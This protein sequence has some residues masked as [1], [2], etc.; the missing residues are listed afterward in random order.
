[1]HTGIME[2]L[3]QKI[4]KFSPTLNRQSIYTQRSRLSRI[5]IN[6][7]IHVVRFAWKR[8]IGKKAKIMRRVAFPQELDVLDLCTDDLRE[9]L[10]PVNKRLKEIENLMLLNKTREQRCTGTCY[11]TTA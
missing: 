6:L 4:E 10:T 3:N 9:K 5:P 11:T 2:A 8:E 7:M 1:M